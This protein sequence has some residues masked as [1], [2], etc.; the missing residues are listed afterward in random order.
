M[1]KQVKIWTGCVKDNILLQN[2]LFANGYH[3]NS[4]DSTLSYLDATYLTIYPDEAMAYSLNS[5]AR[6]IRADGIKVS[7]SIIL[8]ALDFKEFMRG[9]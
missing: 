7:L 1:A 8:A 4:G 3:W 5:K 9:L 6:F 2:I